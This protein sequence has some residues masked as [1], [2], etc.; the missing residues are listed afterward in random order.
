MLDKLLKVS[1]ILALYGC[2]S[3][4]LAAIILGAYL[5]YAWQIDYEKWIKMLAIAQGFEI[6]DIQQ[7]V[8]DRIAEMSYEEVLEHRAKRTREDEFQHESVAKTI[9][10]APPPA[11]TPVEEKKSEQKDDS[12]IKAFEKRLA[13][14]KKKA[15]DAGLA[16]E[17]R[18]LE[19]ME[20]EQAKEVI[21][22]FIK[23]GAMQ[24]VLTMLLAMEE[25]KRGEILYAMQ[26]EEELKD[27]CDILQRIGNGEPLTS[28][29]DNA[30][31]NGNEKKDNTANEKT[32]EKTPK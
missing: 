28:L 12:L 9:V 14:E 16:E 21:R 30:A 7:A 27:L 26:G 4:F 29:I 2:T 10:V 24:R 18:L 25:K 13:E 20:P 22:R 32:N 19:S 3:M 5:K 11:E 1:G 15:N 23:D 8:E 31:Q 17:T 6:A